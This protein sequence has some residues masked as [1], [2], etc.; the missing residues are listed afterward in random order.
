MG[1][2]FYCLCSKTKIIP[3]EKMLFLK[4][5][6]KIEK[7]WEKASARVLERYIRKPDLDRW[8]R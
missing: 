2:S 7:I 8:I 3:K 5:R 1:N 6:N 4:Y